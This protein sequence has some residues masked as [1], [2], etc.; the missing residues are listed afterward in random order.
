[1]RNKQFSIKPSLLTIKT[2]H[3]TK[4]QKNN[5]SVASYYAATQP[6]Q[7]HPNVISKMK[8]HY[9]K[10][11]ILCLRPRFSTVKRNQDGYNLGLWDEFGYQ[12]LPKCRI[13]ISTCWPAVQHASTVLRLPIAAF[14]K[15]L[16]LIMMDI[17][18]DE[19][20]FSIS[21]SYIKSGDDVPEQ[22]WHLEEGVSC[23]TSWSGASMKDMIMWV[24]W[25]DDKTLCSHCILFQN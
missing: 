15:Y 13:D 18:T 23:I 25:L 10:Q 9:I 3:N 24:V 12:T 6:L 14:H 4:L 16:P 11:N 19:V 17:P 5:F 8:C 20:T 7:S 1:M 22:R 2:P 21:P